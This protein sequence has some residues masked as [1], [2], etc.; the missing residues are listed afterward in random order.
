[1]KTQNYKNHG[2][3]VPGYHYVLFILIMAMLIGGIIN[4][5]KSGHENFYS[6][7]LLIL[8]AVILLF[9]SFYARSFSLKAQDRSIK[10]EENFRHY[11]LTGK[12][13]SNDLTMRQIIGLRFAS[14][15]EFPDLAKKAV[16]E[17]LSEKDIKESIKNW[18]ADNYR[19]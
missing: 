18:K 9:L 4:A 12:P 11:L 19:V 10:V 5:I 8:A 6:A 17:S 16:S 7:T 13:L 3:M 14:D 1:M 2:R 15:E